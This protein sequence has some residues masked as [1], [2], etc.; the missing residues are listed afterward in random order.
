MCTR[1]GK[2]NFRL[3]KTNVRHIGIFFSRLLLRPYS[4]VFCIRLSNFVR[5]GQPA[6]DYDVIYNFKMATAVAQ[7]YFRF[8]I[9]R[10]KSIRKP[11][12]VY[13]FRLRIL[14]HGLDITT[15]ALEKQISAIKYPLCD[16]DQMAVVI[17]CY[18]E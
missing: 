14:I 3:G 18:S 9:R 17:A 4:T 7:Y 10:S 6:A 5:I 12:F 16:F 1:F 13:T 2:I 11:N 8:R 15:F